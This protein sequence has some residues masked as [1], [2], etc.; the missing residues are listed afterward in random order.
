MKHRLERRYGFG[1]LHFITCSCYR[2]MPFLGSERARI[3][4]LRILDEVRGRYD[5]ALFEYVVML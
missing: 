3:L 4:F 5:F 2:R 1:Q